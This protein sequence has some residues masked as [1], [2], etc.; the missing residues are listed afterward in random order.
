MDRVKTF[1]RWLELILKFWLSLS[2]I[3][4]LSQWI[5]IE[6]AFI[7]NLAMKGILHYKIEGITNTT[8]PALALS[9]K[10]K[11][12]ATLANCVSHLPLWIGLWI[13]IRLFQNYQR[14]EIF[15]LTNALFYKKL[16]YLL[17]INALIVK[18]IGEALTVLS[19]T[20]NNP[21]GQRVLSI[22]FSSDNLE[23]LFYGV[24]II[25]ISWIMKEAYCLQEERNLTV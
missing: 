3:I 24:M 4:G 7:K 10:A 20:L 22:G 23:I 9:G 14:G 17:C 1:S 8:F 6:S 21:V 16:G 5:W 2:I 19:L 13:L 15:T 11:A 25:V 12:L 18:V